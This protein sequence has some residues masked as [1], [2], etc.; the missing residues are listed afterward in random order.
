MYDADS[1]VESS[2]YKKWS[3]PNK[4]S[5]GFGHIYWKNFDKKFSLC[6]GWYLVSI[7]LYGI[8]ILDYAWYI[9]E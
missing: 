2:L 1:S 9:L 8:D 5:S 7:I 6:S 3:F 4:V